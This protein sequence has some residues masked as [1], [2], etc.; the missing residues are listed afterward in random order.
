MDVSWLHHPNKGTTV[1]HE[2]ARD[3]TSVQDSNVFADIPTEHHHRKHAPSS[4]G[5]TRDAK[6][7]TSSH[8]GH[9]PPAEV[10]HDHNKFPFPAQPATPVVTEAPKE[11]STASPATPT[12][13]ATSKAQQPKRPNLLNRTSQEKL[14]ADSSKGSRRNSWISN[15]SSKFSSSQVQPPPASPGLKQP[16]N[17]ASSQPSTNGVLSPPQNGRREEVEE[18]APY[19]P[20]K[21]KDSSSFF[22]SL[23]RRL[24]SAQGGN[25]AKAVENGGVCPRRV[26]NVDP[27]RERC[28]VPELDQAKLRRV[29]FCVDVEI[30][31]GPRYRD[32]DDGT[33]R[34]KKKKKEKLQ[35]RG[36]GEALKHP[37]ALKEEKEK[38]GEIK[39]PAE[40]VNVPRMPKEESADIERDAVAGSPPDGDGD[41]DDK[42]DGNKKKE[43]KKRSE[44]ERKERKEKRRRKAEESGAVPVELTREESNSPPSSLAPTPQ[45]GSGTTTPKNQDKPTTDPVRIYRRCCQLRETP[46][47]KRITEQLMSPTC[48]L[49]NEPGVVSCLNLTG[50]RL[51]LADVVTLSDW[52]AVV[53]VKRLLLEDADLNDEGVRVIL[54]GLLAAKRPEPTRRKAHSPKHSTTSTPN[55]KKAEE[56]TGIVE[57]ITFKNNP[58]ITRIGW[59]HIS[60]FIYMCRSIKAIDLSMLQF[61]STLP[62]SARCTPVKAPEKA[63]VTRGQDTDAAETLYKS[64][65]ERLGGSKLEELSMSECGLNAQQIRKIIDGV[66]VGGINRL[67]LAGN[68]LDDKGLD[69]VLRYLRSGVCNALDL[70]SNDLRGKL[71]LIADALTKKPDIPCWGLSLA[72]C[73]LDSASLKPLFPALVSM[74]N[75]RFIDLS[76]NR[77]LCTND[78]NTVGLLR[79]YMGKLTE[80]KR[81]HLSDVG[82][83]PK[84]AIA[85]AEVLPEG[86]ALAHLSILENP[87]LSALASATDETSQEE[88]CALYA[89]LMAAVRVSSTIICIDIDVPSPENSEV[90]KALAKQVVAYCLRNMD[91]WTIQEANTINSDM[92]RAAASTLAEPHGGQKEIAVPDVLLHLVGHVE[93]FHENHDSDDPAP[94]SDYIVGGTGVV[95]ALQYVLGE[96][97]SDLRRG[98]YP[99]SGSATP[100]E[101]EREAGLERERKGKA[102]EMSKNLLGSARKIRA[103]LQPAILKESTA[104][105]E[106]AYRRLLFLDATLQSMVQRFEDEYPETRLTPPS[107]QQP[108]LSTSSVHS[109]EMAAAPGLS[110]SLTTLATEASLEKSDDEEDEVRPKPERHNSDVSL[111]SRALS[112]EEGRIHRLGQNLRREVLDSPNPSRP[113]TAHGEEDTRLEALG[114]RLESISGSDLKTMVQTDGWEEVLRKVGANIDDLRQLQ[115]QDPIGWESFKESQMKAR[116]NLDME[117]SAIA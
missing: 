64:L 69:H 15:I 13:S 62:P 87:Q 74:P 9:I 1:S 104:G 66:V 38:E 48:T 54:A 27:N 105:D 33:D 107:P 92:A 34:K 68:N 32:D 49:L 45:P 26:L 73:N 70:G 39:I 101:R 111:A 10:H 81:I 109:S 78:N 100:V 56:R 79:K 12:P 59:K 35:E 19:C 86:P 82:L 75:F 97:A 44:E 61:P 37:E 31:G 95:K 52:L 77:D 102:K 55:A 96:K 14:S 50:S 90:V 58:R 84:Q 3:S 47:L 85:L 60:C 114:Q 21:P 89:S 29:S 116:M 51:Q 99:V 36:E 106:M 67:G 30:A 40:A 20:S 4:P 11:T 115:E 98:S 71:G 76:H 93:G 117:G 108:A 16:V 63:P 91:R 41:E 2:R 17:G 83:S 94:D 88:A 25:L 18:L 24:S 46:I 22:T 103:R 6:P 28:L 7:P 110:S 72:G 112:L 23:T 80:L 113:P 57:K 42:K 8:G 43:K 53:P 65:S 5:L